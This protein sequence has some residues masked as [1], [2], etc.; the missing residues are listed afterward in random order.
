VLGSAAS[1]AAGGGRPSGGNTVDTVIQG[2]GA[3]TRTFKAL[4]LDE[5]DE[6]AMG[7]SVALE[8]SARHKVVKDDQLTKYVLMV[9]QTLCD[10]TPSGG[11]P[12]VLVLDTSE[13]NAY[14]GP[15]GYIMITRGL[16]TRMEDE[17]ELAGVLGH[18]IGHVAEQHG[19]KNVRDSALGNLAFDA[20]SIATRQQAY[21]GL[22]KQVAGPMLDSVYSQGQEKEADRDALRLV[23]AAGYD[24]QGYVRILQRIE[25]DQKGKKLFPTHPDI[26]SRIAAAQAQ[27]REENLRGGQTNRERFL[28]MTKG[29]RR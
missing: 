13:V 11:R 16:L 29:I 5:R 8:A 9:T 19:L 26:P 12:V 4:S 10:G 28:A 3:V 17:S 22:L 24:P 27:I 25:P 2:A 14:S 20:T 6:R 18:E 21:V 15:S 23:A 7:Q 1:I